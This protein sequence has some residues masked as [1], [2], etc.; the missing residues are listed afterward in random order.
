VGFATNTQLIAPSP[1]GSLALWDLAA[2]QIVGTLGQAKRQKDFDLSP[3]GRL[4]A[5][6][7]GGLRNE[8]PITSVTT[9]EHLSEVPN[10]SEVDVV[11][12]SP[13]GTQLALAAFGAGTRI[14]DRSGHVTQVLTDPGFD[15][16]VARFSPDGNTI[17]TASWSEAPETRHVTIRGRDGRLLRTIATDASGGLEFDPSGSTVA[18]I[19]G[20]GALTIWNADDWTKIVVLGGSPAVLDVDFSPDGSTIATGNTDGTVRLYDV[21]T[22]AQRLVLRG[23]RWW[24]TSV[25]FSPD[26]AKLASLSPGEVRVWA[27]DLDDLLAIAEQEVSRSFTDEECRRY[28]HVDR[29]TE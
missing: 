1:D 7:S 27:L 15:S 5:I 11:D 28:L 25:A 19:T 8:V 4:I 17:A 26:G 29:C 2:G 21:R 14:V 22:G 24:V 16:Y 18:T 12:W 10:P 13:D 9:G 3:D 6:A 20:V 23:H